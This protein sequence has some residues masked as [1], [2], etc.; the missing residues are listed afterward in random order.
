MK[1]LFLIIIISAFSLLAF[2]QKQEIVGTVT[3]TAGGGTQNVE[4][5]RRSDC[6]VISGSGTLTSS[7]TIQPSGT[8]EKWT[9]VEFD[10]RGPWVLSGN[11]ITIFGYPLTAIQA[12]NNQSIRTTYTGSTWKVEVMPNYTQDGI[13][14]D[15]LFTANCIPD[16][17]I[18]DDALSLTKLDM[19]NTSSLVYTAATAVATELPLATT[20]FAVGD[21]TTINA[22]SMSN[23][24]TMSN[25]GAVTISANAV[26]NTKLDDFTGQGYIKVGGAAGAPTDVDF[27][28]DGY[29]GIGDGTD[30][31]SVDVTGDI[32]ITNAG[33][34]TI[35][36]GSV[37]IAMMTSDAQKE[38]IVIPVSF[39]TGEIT[40]TKVKI[41]YKC[42]VTNVYAIVV[43]LIEATDDATMQL[44]DHGGTN[45]TG[46]LITATA[47]DPLATAYSSAVTAN[48][49]IASGELLQFAA[50]KTTPGGKIIVTIELTRGD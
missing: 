1:K 15:R 27:N 12:L 33:I 21:G 30:F 49:A 44:K 13:L 2:A 17:A 23:D 34:T 41:P 47:G 3:L 43:K 32:E 35:Q 31:N 6:I 45:M 7:W 20:E 4:M 29:I 22:V 38:V 19:T 24:A 16:S 40:T 42:T 8:P 26:D 18:K 37:D 9:V 25:T 10:Y 14:E 46:G 50:A 39:E 11:N 36:A 48:N 5:D 28:D